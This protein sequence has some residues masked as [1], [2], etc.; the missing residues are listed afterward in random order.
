MEFEIDL[1]IPGRTA[2][3][4]VFGDGEVTI[5]LNDGYQGHD[6]ETVSFELA[7]LEEMVKQAKAHRD[8][9]QAFAANDYEE[10]IMPEIGDTVKPDWGRHE[11][12]WGMVV[13]VN[14]EN[15]SALINFGG[16]VT[17]EDGFKMPDQYWSSI[18]KIEIKG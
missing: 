15:L 4:T 18:K 7:E 11:G 5:S 10:I 14:N 3:L 12:K 6:P 17:A 16:T 2:G 1:N 9:Y 8:A 13:K